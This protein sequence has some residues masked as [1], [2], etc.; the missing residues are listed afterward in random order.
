MSNLPLVTVG[1]IQ[2]QKKSIWKKLYISLAGYFLGNIGKKQLMYFL[3]KQS[4]I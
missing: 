3:K 1:K 2:V 4:K